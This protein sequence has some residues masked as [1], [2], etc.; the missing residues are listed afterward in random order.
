MTG[1]VLSIPSPG[2]SAASYWTAEHEVPSAW[3]E[4]TP[5]GSWLVEAME[6]RTIVE[7]GTHNGL[8][9]FVFAEASRRL[10]LDT[11]L[12]AIDSWEGDEQAGFY[13]EDVYESVLA[14]A[15]EFY[16][17]STELIRAYF[18]DAVTR[19][20]HG[21]ID[22]LHVDGR[23]S[24]DDVRADFETYQSTLSTR[25]VVLFHDTHEIQPTFGVHRF[26]DELATTAPS[27]AFHHGHGL[28][29]LAFGSEVS[30]AVLE[31]IDAANR[32]P[33]AYRDF[34][35]AR[36][37]A[38]SRRTAR[39]EVAEAREDE[40]ENLRRELRNYYEALTEANGSLASARAHLDDTLSSTS[41][42][43]T[44]P[45]R[46]ITGSIKRTR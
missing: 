43:F 27:F 21:S 34:Y 17:T 45:L 39:D 11:R 29:V 33:D 13:G 46:S 6:P 15:N 40:V 7:L 8:S 28:G 19:F 9:F 14:I 2:I 3:R 5:F 25:A 38:I 18:A 30:P 4:H 26:W 42:K 1:T 31:F 16:P 41:W 23:H 20:D 32:D 36:G 12:F 44:A 37:A 10:G 22:L 35:R 24:Y